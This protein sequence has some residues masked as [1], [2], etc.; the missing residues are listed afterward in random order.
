MTYSFAV[1]RDNSNGQY[2]LAKATYST[3]FAPVFRTLSV[4]EVDS[5]PFIADIAKFLLAQEY[6]MLVPNSEVTQIRRDFPFY[7]IVFKTPVGL[8][9]QI[10]VMYNFWTG[11]IDVF[12]VTAHDKNF[13]SFGQ[14]QQTVR[15]IAI[16]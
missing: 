6:S 7:L 12:S 9:M 16:G 1:R 10:V 11:K 2:L 3:L 8:D 14:I 15:Q 5:E 4:S 13:E